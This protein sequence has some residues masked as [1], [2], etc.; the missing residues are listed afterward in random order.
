MV[1]DLTYTGLCAEEAWPSPWLVLIQTGTGLVAI[2][3][4]VWLVHNG[5]GFHFRLIILWRRLQTH[6]LSLMVAAWLT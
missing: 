4:Q 2:S 5:S 3:L 6:E 1:G